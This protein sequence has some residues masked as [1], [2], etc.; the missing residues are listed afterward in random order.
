MSKAAEKGKGE[1]S[2]PSPSQLVDASL[3]VDR[4]RSPSASESSLSEASTTSSDRS[5][6]SRLRTYLL[7]DLLKHDSHRA[8]RSKYV[9]T[10][11]EELSKYPT[12]QTRIADIKRRG[13]DQVRAEDGNAIS[14]TVICYRKSDLDGTLRE[15]EILAPSSIRFVLEGGVTQYHDHVKERIFQ[16]ER[17]VVIDKMKQRLATVQNAIDSG[18]KKFAAT[19]EAEQRIENEIVELRKKRYA[20]RNESDV[21]GLDEISERIGVLYRKKEQMGADATSEYTIFKEQRQELQKEEEKLTDWLSPRNVKVLD[22]AIREFRGHSEDYLLDSIKREGVLREAADYSKATGCDRFYLVITSTND[23]CRRCQDR[24]EEIA[25]TSEAILNQSQIPGAV[26]KAL[27]FGGKL[28]T[29]R[30]GE[31]HVDYRDGDVANLSDEEEIVI[32]H[33]T[34]KSE[35]PKP[36]PDR[37]RG[38]VFE[39]RN[40][41]T[42]G[43]PPPPSR[44]L[45][46]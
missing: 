39:N 16:E 18:V 24:V 25:I 27:Y 23:A 8:S 6:V 32:G 45:S 13:A 5:S 17:G 15:F 4:Q 9:I 46:S 36:S 12:L 19:F 14:M 35:S 31:S 10:D 11:R 20:A 22:D 29:D 43:N 7:H 28:F 30:H 41:F 21:A 3:K 44:L 37:A 26:C 40:L 2:S 33:R 38:G 1:F 42:A 34:K